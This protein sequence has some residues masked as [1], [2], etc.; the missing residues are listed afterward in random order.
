MLQRYINFFTD[1]GFKRLF[2]SE[3]IKICLIDFLNG[4][5]VGKKQPIVDLQYRNPEKPGPSKLDRN[6]IFDIYCVT[7]DGTRF[8]V[9]LQK[10]KQKFFKDRAFFYS[11]FSIQEQAIQGEWDF[12][13]KDRMLHRQSF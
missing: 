2:G 12:E 10:A 8:I 9:E 6:A 11:A 3:P 5:L 7:S 1:Y 4:L 13:G